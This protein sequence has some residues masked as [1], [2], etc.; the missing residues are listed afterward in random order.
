MIALDDRLFET[1]SEIVFR[2]SGIKISRDRKEWVARKL[3]VRLDTLNLS[4]INKYINK[5]LNDIKEE[6]IKYFLDIITINET[7]FFRNMPQLEIFRDIVIPNLIKEKN[8]K[9]IRIWSAGCSVGCEPYTL[10]ILLKEI[11]L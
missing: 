6:E 2:K 9:K 4:D 7:Y 8:D 5:L 11:L 3:K 1:I 10:A